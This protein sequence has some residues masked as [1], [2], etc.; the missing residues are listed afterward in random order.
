VFFNIL[1]GI[2]RKVIVGIPWTFMKGKYP[3]KTPEPIP[4]TSGSEASIP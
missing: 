2:L 3:K 1:P 4:K